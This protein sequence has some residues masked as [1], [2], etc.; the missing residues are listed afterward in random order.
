VRRNDD[1]RGGNTNESYSFHLTSLFS[2]YHSPKG[3]NLLS[4][5]ET[6][7]KF[8]LMDGSPV[9][10]ESIPVRLFLAGFD[11]T[12][13]YHGSHNKFS[14]RYYLNL[15]LIDEEDRRFF[16]QQGMEMSR[17]F[18]RSFVH[19]FILDCALSSSR[20]NAVAQEDKIKIE[21]EGQEE[22]QCHD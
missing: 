18:I 11:L 17:S 2:F 19:S 5:N 14:V 22:R 15:V 21:E 20:N 1:G 3:P 9:K 7:A 13:S 4:E 6:V 8:E 16:K 12:P 10:G